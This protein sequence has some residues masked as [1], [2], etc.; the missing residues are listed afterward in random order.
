MATT[1]TVRANLDTVIAGGGY[2]IDLTSIAGVSATGLRIQRITITSPPTSV[3]NVTLA[4]G[5]SNGRVI[6]G[7]LVVPPGG[8]AVAIYNDYGVDIDGTH[9]TLDVSGTDGDAP[10][11]VVE[12]A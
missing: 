2:T 3:G 6:P 4:T 5:A 9:K 1:S 10:L 11:I 7:A 12:C 8:L